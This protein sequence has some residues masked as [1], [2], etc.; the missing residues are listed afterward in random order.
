[1]KTVIVLW[2][3]LLLAL[4]FMVG[5]TMAADADPAVTAIAYSP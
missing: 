3:C 5:P 4:M 2:S 1:M